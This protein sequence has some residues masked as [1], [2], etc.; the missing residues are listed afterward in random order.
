M[1]V[2][3]DHPHRPRTQLAAEPPVGATDDGNGMSSLCQLTAEEQ[4]VLDRA[5]DTGTC[6]DFY[7]THDAV[8]AAD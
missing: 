8:S 5:V 4:T 1:Q 2:R 6:N 7:N 3:L